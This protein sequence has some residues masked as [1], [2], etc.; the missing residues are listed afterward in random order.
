MDDVEIIAEL[1]E[2]ARREVIVYDL[3]FLKAEDV[4]LLFA[5]EALDKLKPEADGVDVPGGDF[6]FLGRC[7]YGGDVAPYRRG[8]NS[9]ARKPYGRDAAVLPARSAPGL[10]LFRRGRSPA[11]PWPTCEQ[12]GRA[13]VRTPVTNATLVCRLL[14]ET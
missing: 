5:Q 3:G 4:G 12:I 9:R 8:S 7:R 10:R 14:L 2:E 11:R 6:Q 1:P 13:H